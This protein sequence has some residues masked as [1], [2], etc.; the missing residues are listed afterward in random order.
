MTHPDLEALAIQIVRDILSYSVEERALEITALLRELIAPLEGEIATAKHDR[1]VSRQ[2]QAHDEAAL[3][4]LNDAADAVLREIG[5]PMPQGS[6]FAEAALC[7]PDEVR[8]LA[9]ERDAALSKQIACE[10][11]VRDTEETF[12]A[13][14][15]DRN[16]FLRERD[17][18]KDDLVATEASRDEARL[19]LDECWDASGL[20]CSRMTGQ[21]RQSWEQ[22][23]DLIQQITELAERA[24]EEGERDT[25]EAQRDAA[26]R[27]VAGLIRHWPQFIEGM[28]NSGAG[29]IH[30]SD[31]EWFVQTKVGMDGYPDRDSAVRAAAKLDEK[32]VR[33]GS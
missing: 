28:E 4:R 1:D 19:I 30:E 32:G 29:V 14:E 22:G 25:L 9:Q 18:A 20:L 8:R 11:A 15:S 16:R 10:H 24:G 26:L 23:D 7:L 31:G 13:V 12:S 27:E 17:E 3:K 21:P 33:D 5:Q 2:E 6:G